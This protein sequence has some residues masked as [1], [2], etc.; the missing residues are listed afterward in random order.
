M[1]RGGHLV[2]DLVDRLTG[3]AQRPRSARHIH[4]QGIADRL[5]HVECFQQRQLLG[6]GFEQI[7]KTDHHGL[8]FGR[9]QPRP[10]ARLEG[11]ART[12]HRTVGI[13]LVAAGYLSQ[14]PTVD[15]ADAI[16]VGAGGG[17]AVFT[18]D[19]GPAFDVQVAGALLPVGESQGGH[20][21]SSVNGPWIRQAP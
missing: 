5:A 10:G 7:G 15:R 6:I 16:E 4:R 18:L 19:E 11:H 3:P 8:A 12:E 21:A 9:C 20:G 13:G 2:V 17:C 1:G 14:H